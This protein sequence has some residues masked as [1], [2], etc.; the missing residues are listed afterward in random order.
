M[1]SSAIFVVAIVLTV[2]FTAC[3]GPAKDPRP[4]DTASL[5]LMSGDGAVIDD[6]RGRFREIFC[7]VLED[8]GRDLP[9][10]R[11]CE[12]ALNRTDG[13]PTGSGK[14]VNLG[15]STENFLVGL[16]PGFGWQ[17]VREWLD[18]DNS[19]SLHVANYGFDTRLIEV[20]GLSSPENNAAQIRDYIVDLS[21]KE[22]QRQVVLIGHSK[23]TV[24][25]LQ[26]IVTYPEVRQHVVAVV[27]VAGA[28]GGSMLAENT[29]Q[30]RGSLLTHIPKSGCETGDGGALQSLH[31]QTR[32]EW[33]AHNPLPEGIH[34]YSLVA[35]PDREHLSIGLRN[36]YK[37]LA[38][39]DN[40]NDGQ[41]I[42]YD[43]FIPGATLLAFV[44]ADHWAISTPV[45]RQLPIAQG[46]FANRTKYP[47][48]V[49][50]EATLR[51][52]E[53]DLAEP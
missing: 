11:P 30:K 50:L 14:P 29:S 42:F 19:A 18:E 24:D 45:A 28:V 5:A 15:L 1:K 6:G 48:E 27:S 12:E 23:G 4:A 3:A 8:H 9:D 39:I 7:T 35:I 16:V 43:Q 31:R 20:D 46:T 52:I 25:I 53:E 34:Y 51:F 26:A 13:E 10:Y 33:L 37:K 40:R 49:L 17:C 21:A 22:A 41:L 47:R 32:K 2:S 36:D 38:E 44:N